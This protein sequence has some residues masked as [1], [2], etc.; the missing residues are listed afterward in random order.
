MM[1]KIDLNEIQTSFISTQQYAIILQNI[2]GKA[3]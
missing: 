2:K 1:Y 3:L